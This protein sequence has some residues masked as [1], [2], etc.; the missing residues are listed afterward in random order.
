MK[1][2]DEIENQ[3]EDRVVEGHALPRNRQQ[4][5]SH[6]TFVAPSLAGVH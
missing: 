3:G 6:F 4:Q 2:F 5:V 1:M